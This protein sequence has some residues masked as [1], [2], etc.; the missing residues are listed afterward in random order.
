[1]RR[2]REAERSLLPALFCC[3]I[4]Q[5]WFKRS[6]MYSGLEVPDKDIV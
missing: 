2:K 1:M 4:C 3:N 5:S 6:E